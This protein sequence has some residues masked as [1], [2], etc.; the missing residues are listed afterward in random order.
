LLNGKVVCETAFVDWQAQNNSVIDDLRKIIERLPAEQS[1]IL[2]EQ[3]ITGNFDFL[4]LRDFIFR[5]MFIEYKHEP[6]SV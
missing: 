6:S 1:V 5:E 2:I 4:G 3:G